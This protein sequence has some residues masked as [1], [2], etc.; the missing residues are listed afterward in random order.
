M[1]VLEEHI[2]V[3][4]ISNMKILHTIDTSP[5]PNGLSLKSSHPLIDPFQMLVRTRILSSIHPTF[6]FE[7]AS[8]H[9]KS[10][11]TSS[12]HVSPLRA[13]AQQ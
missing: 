5:N 9:L 2:H 3:Y 4:D 7:H 1:V 6:S 11:H 8:Y 10:S 13:F 12:H